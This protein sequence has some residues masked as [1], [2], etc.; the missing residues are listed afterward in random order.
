MGTPVIVSDGCAGREEIVDGV[1]GLWFESASAE[2]LA[3]KLEM[4]KDDER[5]AKMSNAAYDQF[6]SDPPTLARHV[7]RLGGVYAE[8]LARRRA[9]A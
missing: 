5:I 1:S 4:A 2:S 9:A 7:E 3:Q 6:W 8:V